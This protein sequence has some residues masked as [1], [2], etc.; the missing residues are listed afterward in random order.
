VWV[1]NYQ[2]D[3]HDTT[4]SFNVWLGHN[5][6][7]AFEGWYGT[8]Q[9]ALFVREGAPASTWLAHAAFDKAIG[10]D[11]SPLR[12]SLHP[13]EFLSLDLRWHANTRLDS[14]Y[15]VFVHLGQSDQAPIAQSDSAPAGGFEPTLGWQPGQLVIDRRAFLVPLDAPP[16]VYQLY[17]GLYDSATGSR[18]LLT[19]PSGC[20]TADSVCLG[21]VEIVPAPIQTDS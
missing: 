3:I 17:A 15:T 8:S 10:L 2:T 13:G 1:A 20:D 16:G 5:A 11:Y 7:L 14:A 6:A 9:L 21:S 4:N 18:L 19:T 12:V